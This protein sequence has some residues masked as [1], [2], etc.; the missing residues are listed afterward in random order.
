MRG[1]WVRLPLVEINWTTNTQCLESKRKRLGFL[2]QSK[3]TLLYAEYNVR[4]KNKID[5]YFHRDYITK[6]ISYK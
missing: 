3:G 2:K 4:L 6:E 1:L 5:M